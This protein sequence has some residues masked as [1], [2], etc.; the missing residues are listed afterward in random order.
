MRTLILAVAL[1]FPAV[2]SAAPDGVDVRMPFVEEALRFISTQA[3]DTPPEAA[4]LRAGVV[5]VCGEDGARPGCRPQGVPWPVQGA[6]GPDAVG[7]WRRILESVV[8]AESLQQGARFDKVAFERFVADGMV[9]ALGD[10]GSFYIAPSIYKKIASIPASF[11]GFGLRPVPVQGGL[12]VAAVHPGSPAQAAGLAAGDVVTRVAGEPVTGYRRSIALAAIWG[13]AGETL[14]L[15]V[16]TAAGASRDVRLKYKP[17]TFTPFAIERVGDVAVVRIRHFERGLVDA[18]REAIA[19]CSGVVLDVRDA[20]SGLDDE[21][22]GVADLFLGG[23]SIGSQKGRSDLADRVWEAHAGSP[24][25]RLDVPVAV[26]MNRGTGGLAEVLA[27]SL[28]A[29]N[30][31]ILVGEITGGVD[32]Q[33][34]LRLFTEGSAIQLTSVR[35]LG[36]GGTALGEGVLPHVKTDRP[37]I[38]DMAAAIVAGAQGPALDG[39]IEIARRAVA[40]P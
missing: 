20:S 17:W 27:A 35:F 5:K 4:L 29:A 2:V 40:A 36:P 9:E 33:E 26:V 1:V 6:T 10:P 22:T 15:T 19:S 23:G 31:A 32:T 24:G 18:V 12:L 30:R 3:L 14:E 34:T 7:V 13:A 21:M 38:V 25:E 37:R 16:R 8:A 39:L 11:V 28:R